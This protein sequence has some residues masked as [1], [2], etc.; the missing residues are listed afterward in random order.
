M[1]TLFL[2]TFL[3]SISLF[4]QDHDDKKEE[5]NL[6]GGLPREVHPTEKATKWLANLQNNDGSWG[7]DNK[8]VLSSYVMLCFAAQGE[9]PHS[10]RY[11]KS[12]KKLLAYLSEE[13][14]Q[15]I[16]I[17]KA[18]FEGA[19]ILMALNE[20]AFMSGVKSVIPLCQQLDLLIK[21]EF[22]GDHWP[23][24]ENELIH[25]LICIRSFLYSQANGTETVNRRPY[26]NTAIDWF[27]DTPIGEPNKE[28]MIYSGYLSAYIGSGHTEEL[29]SETK[30]LKAHKN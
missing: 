10:K 16:K 23:T 17:Q 19:H 14:K 2:T 30:R 18:G 12:I 21:S 28:R 27:N 22:N 3:I 26:I 25:N 15:I 6:Y 29:E 11:G 24:K 8:R 20:M 4:S 9:T 5:V 13:A 7:K 1:R